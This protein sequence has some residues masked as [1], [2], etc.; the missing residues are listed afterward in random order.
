MKRNLFFLIIFSGSVAFSQ[1]FDINRYMPLNIK[2][3]VENS[4]RSYDGKP[5][6]KYVQNELSYKITAELHPTEGKVTGSEEI[7]FKN[8]FDATLEDLVFR[9]YQDSFKKGVMRDFQIDPADLHDGTI[10]TNLKINGVPINPEGDKV[11]RY[12][13]TMSVKLDEP[14]PSGGSVAVSVS[15]EVQ[16]PKINRVRMG[17][18]NDS[19]FFVAY[20]YPQISV[21]DDLQG[22]D[23]SSYTMNHEFYNNFADFDVTITVPEGYLVWATGELQNPGEVYSDELLKLYNK[24]KGSEEV[25]HII[26]K[27][28]KNELKTQ[29]GK[30]RFHYTAKYVPDFAFTSA[31][32][33]L[34]DASVMTVDA[35]TGRKTF[36]SAVYN[37]NSKDFYD[38]AEIARKAIKYLSEDLPGVPYPYPAMTVFNGQ[39]G[40][41]F[42]M[43]VNDGSTESYTSA[44]GLTSH[45]IAHTWFPF[46]MGTNEVK[47]AHMDEGWAV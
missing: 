30:N 37:E 21:Y 17:K 20:W 12:G 41:E 29:K 45:E 35:K 2:K 24:A 25:V 38:V 5:G 36:I 46:F 15:W 8:N 26:S 1:N 33:Y 13:T 7:I 19:T 18:Y 3:A 11:M 22:W 32:D 43:M 31:V 39:G 28:K 44:V 6:A 4:T 40:M 34:W 42:P 27:E 10:I 14:I 47:Y 16:L 9:L 23:M